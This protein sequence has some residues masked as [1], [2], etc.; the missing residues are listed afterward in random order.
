[1]TTTTKR[2]TTCGHDHEVPIPL[3]NLCGELCGSERSAEYG[4]MGL[5]NC[6]VSGGYSST[7][8]N[9]DGALDD[10]S[11]YK[12]SMCEFCLDWLFT[13]FRTPPQVGHYSIGT[14]EETGES[15]VFRPAEQRVREDEWRRHKEEF[16]AERAR[17]A[18]LRERKE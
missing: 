16:A 5:I 10:C 2:C 6:V 8:G 1:V 11:S 13:Q 7:P 17:R 14:G 9:G 12:F 3:C 15:E 4:A 18:V